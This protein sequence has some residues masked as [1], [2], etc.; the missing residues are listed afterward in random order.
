MSGSIVSEVK[1]EGGVSGW[2][3]LGAG[4]V[5]GTVVGAEVVVGTVVGAEV[6]VGTVVGAEVVVGTVVGAEVVVG[7]VVGAEVVVGTVVG[8]EV[9]VGTVVGAEVVVGTVVGAEVVVGT[10]VG[11]EVVV[12]TVVGAEVV[13]GTVV[14]AG[15]GGDVVEAVVEDGIMVMLQLCSLSCISPSPGGASIVCSG[16][17]V[18]GAFS[19]LSLGQLLR[20]L[21]I[22]FPD[23]SSSSAVSGSCSPSLP[24]LDS[25]L[26]SF[27][28][29]V[30][31]PA[32]T[33]HAA[34]KAAASVIAFVFGHES[35][36]KRQSSTRSLRR[37]NF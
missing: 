8:A 31:S 12:G 3:V 6:V 30:L 33:P 17:E 10:V 22:S 9:V 19:S 37:S 32:P 27:M 23:P 7:T 26:T 1:V 36:L 20:P 25:P 13:V 2:V 29:S 5:V 18:D 11:A 28:V 35:V 21:G 16:A 14:G 4:V 15:V 24:S 34:M